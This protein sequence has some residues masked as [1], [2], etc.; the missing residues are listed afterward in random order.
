MPYTAKTRTGVTQ[1]LLNRCTYAEAQL[2]S[3]YRYLCAKYLAS[4]SRGNTG[5]GTSSPSRVKR[6]R[7]SSTG[8]ICPI[9]HPSIPE[10]SKECNSPGTLGAGSVIT[11]APDPSNPIGCSPNALHTS[12]V[13]G[14][15]G[16]LASSIA[17]PSPDAEAVSCNAVNSP[18]SVMSCMECTSCCVHAIR[19]SGTML[20][21]GESRS[22]ALLSIT[23]SA[24][25]AFLSPSASSPAR[26][27]VPS[28]ARPLVT[29]IL[30]S[31]LR[32]PRWQPA[33]RVPPPLALCPRR[34]DAGCPG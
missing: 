24:T 3:V 4:S 2:P 17:T 15:T 19:A 33:C 12:A 27:A 31:L 30:S 13:S 10:C 6:T 34:W 20:M 7:P 21:P 1:H 18:P 14:R 16:T 5:K 11:S 32:S 22:I 26:I 8:S 23:E 29:T 25:P 9:S 28:M